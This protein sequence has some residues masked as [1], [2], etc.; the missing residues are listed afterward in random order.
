[1]QNKIFNPTSQAEKMSLTYSSVAPSKALYLGNRIF[2]AESKSIAPEELIEFAIL[3]ASS[4][5]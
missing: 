4:Y 2:I 1:M 3:S 5:Q